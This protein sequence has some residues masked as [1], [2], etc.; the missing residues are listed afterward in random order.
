MGVNLDTLQSSGNTGCMMMDRTVQAWRKQKRAELIAARQAMPADERR[1]AG[2]A[3]RAKLERIALPRVGAAIGLYWPIRHEVNLLPWAGAL[4]RSDR[5]TL[6]LPV[7]VSP[8]AP[9]EYRRWVPGEPLQRGVWDIPIPGQGGVLSPDLVLAPLV[10][11]DRAGYRLGYGGGYFDRTLAAAPR[12]PTVIGVGYAGSALETIFPQEHDIPMDA[13]LT[14]GPDI[15][16][17]TWG[18]H[19]A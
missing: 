4:A 11:F 2:D 9:L 16:P 10:G 17:A 6:C 3:I 7:V 14:E 15:L 8:R 5:I 13:I 18:A 1:H 12:R 19:A